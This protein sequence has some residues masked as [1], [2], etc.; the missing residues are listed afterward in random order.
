MQYAMPQISDVVVFRFALVASDESVR[1]VIAPGTQPDSQ[2]S[3][4]GAGS[5]AETCTCERKGTHFGFR[6]PL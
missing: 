2:S 4:R 3:L 6:V 5:L 1:V